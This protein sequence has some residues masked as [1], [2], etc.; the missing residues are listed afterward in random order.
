[1]NNGNISFAD[2]NKTLRLI[3]ASQRQGQREMKEFRAEMR[4]ESRKDKEEMSERSRQAAAEMKEIREESRERWRK[5]DEESRKDNAE[6]RE[7]WRK[8]DEESRKDNAEMRERWRKADEEMEALREQ[9]RKT[10]EQQ[11]K[12]E[13]VVAAMAARVDATSAKV[14]ATSEQVEKLNR[15]MGRFFNGWGEFVEALV[16]PAMPK[17]FAP[18]GFRIDTTSLRCSARRGSRDMEVDIISTGVWNGGSPVTIAVSVKSHLETRDVRDHVVALGDFFKFYPRH[19][20]STLLGAVAGIRVD[21][22]V[23]A[24]SREQG[25]H[26]IGSSGDAVELLTDRDLKPRRWKG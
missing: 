14:D 5:A 20:G 22:N 13:A 9:S 23:P 6:M 8:A 26:L 15:A 11:R 3:I 21:E 4:E 2:M 7:R 18:L 17:M 1:M 19:A 25:L 12:T 10:D 16:A 24:F